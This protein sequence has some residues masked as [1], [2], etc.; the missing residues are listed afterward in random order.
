[1]SFCSFIGNVESDPYW[2]KKFNAYLTILLSMNIIEVNSK[3]S[4]IFANGMSRWMHLHIFEHLGFNKFTG[5]AL[6][7]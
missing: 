4:F 1:M 6:A 2:E 7:F 5:G 3:C